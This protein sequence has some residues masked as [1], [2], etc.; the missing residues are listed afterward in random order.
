MPEQRRTFLV[1]AQHTCSVGSRSGVQR[2]VVE[3]ARS[4]SAIADVEFVKWDPIEGQ[5]R[6][7]DRTDLEDLFRSKTLP[8]GVRANPVAHRVFYRFDETLP[9][10]RRPW[11]IYPEI[12]YHLPDGNDLYARVITQ[13]RE[14]GVPVASV[15]YDLIP[16]TNPH[17]ADFKSQHQVY[18]NRLSRSDLILPISVYAGDTLVAHY[19]ETLS[20]PADVEDLRRRI[21]PLSLAEVNGDAVLRRPDGKTPAG[22]KDVILLLGTV[23]P[24]KQQIEVIKAF[25]RHRDGKL[26]GMRLAIVGSLHPASAEEFHALVDG[27]PSIDYHG[28]ASDALVDALFDRALFSVFASNDE[29]FGLPICESLARGVPCLTASFGSMA[30]VAADGGCLTVDVNDPEEI[31]RGMLKL[32]R[33]A[34][35]RERLTRQIRGKTFRTWE[36]YSRDLVALTAEQDRALD[37]DLLRARIR[38]ELGRLLAGGTPEGGGAMAVRLPPD[39]FGVSWTVFALYDLAESSLLGMRRLMK[40]RP[41]D[42]VAVLFLTPAKV[43]AQLSQD[44]LE[45]LFH[46]DSWTFA[47][48]DVYRAL[49][50]VSCVTGCGLL[51]PVSWAC[52]PEQGALL[53]RAT[54][55]IA[56]FTERR[57]R[58]VLFARRERVLAELGRANP[59]LSRPGGDG[60]LLS[61]VIST[62]NRGPFVAENVRWL[63]GLIEPY[64]GRVTLTVVD[65]ASTD[66]TAERLAPFHGLPNVTI[67]RNCWNVG[68]L[69]NLR[70]CSTLVAAPHMWVIGDDDYIVPEGLAEVVRVLEENP[71]LPLLFANFGVYHR[72]ALGPHDRAENLIGERI[73]LAPD[74]MDS[75]FHPTSRAAEQ[76]DNLFTAVYPIVFRA[77]LLSACFNYTFT[78]APFGSLVE[79]VPTTKLILESYSDTLAYWM[80]QPGIIGNAHNSWRRYRVRWHGVLMPLIFELAKEGG[81]DSRKLHGWARTQWDL[82]KEAMD[83]FPDD[84]LMADFGIDAIEASRRVFLSAVPLHGQPAA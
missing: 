15:F 19:A 36:D 61:I 7:L 35:L 27:D 53:E 74:A 84:T 20:D 11:L 55:Q 28:Y 76:H 1:F 9:R 59:V 48:Y 4:L 83:L 37:R 63:S 22:K 66:D 44:S 70:V 21:I 56:G 65:N 68:M 72:E 58:R 5:L 46:A 6:Y 49:L 41:D 73:L 79:S 38:K 60:P 25:K 33:D 80:K 40:N 8:P 10:D 31:E 64:G 67:R 2:V 71:E 3:L 54:E 16:I 45:F 78:G 32:V 18:V 57:H 82:F 42:R 34:S 12:S 43:K 29:G 69:G 51:A 26:S 75:G 30:E 39:A 47:V 23:E 52:E 62:Y 24:R 13:C 17:Y 81:V 14:Y 50:K 77:D